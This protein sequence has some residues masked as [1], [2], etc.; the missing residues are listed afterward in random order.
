[1]VFAVPSS[2]CA[3][4]AAVTLYAAGSLKAAL[5]EVAAA[6]ERA[7]Q[8][9]IVAKFGP[10]GLLKKEIEEGAAP[11]IF[12]SANMEHP[13]ALVARG[14]GGPVM[15]FAR[16]KLCALTQPGLEIT[17]DRLLDTLMNEKV[18]VGISTPK[19]DP[20]GDYAWELFKRADGIKV[21]S[22]AI[23]SSKSL[24]L[25]GGPDSAKAPEGRNQ[26]GWLMSEKRADVF[27]T[28][29]TNAMAAKEEVPGL[30]IVQIPEWLSVGADYG[31]VVAKDASIEARQ[32]SS[33]ILSPEAQSILSA[34]GFG[35]AAR[36]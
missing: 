26:Y 8:T 20:S 15:L 27:L 31:L 17:G 9:K 21:G 1:M 10:S 12:A 7:H 35:A 13:E 25:S 23:L 14:W 18:R 5:S 6:Y 3:E 24:P 32:F 36:Q 33:Y 30:N 4:P 19:T 34:Y 28:Y 11:D 2:F 29:C 16:N 22:F